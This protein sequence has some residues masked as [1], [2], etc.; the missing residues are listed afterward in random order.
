MLTEILF[1]IFVVL[2]A[3]F[4]IIILGVG[5]FLLVRGIQKKMTNIILAGIAFIGLPLGFIGNVVFNLGPFFQEIFVLI[6]FIFTVL[7]TNLTFYKKKK[8]YPNIVLII[9]IL[10]GSI[11]IV[12]HFLYS[13]SGLNLYYLRV[14][15]D[16]P[17]TLLTF[18][19]LAWAAFQSYRRLRE[20]NI[21]PWIKLRYKLIAIFS[22][23]ISF[24]NVPEF[25]QPKGV[26]WGNPNNIISLAIFGTTAILVIA[27]SIGFFIAWV[28]P[29][30]IKKKINKNYQPSEDKEYTEEEL[31]QLIKTQMDDKANF[32]E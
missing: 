6:A 3:L 32:N 31:M 22:F 18:N 30:W 21:A 17:Y 11:Q 29:N 5:F 7:F 23:I 1:S 10:L 16:L 14:V 13:Y 2:F 8:L 19:W 4:I 20:Y 24:N 28:M 12:L 9:V 26:N 27:F 25:F 15:L